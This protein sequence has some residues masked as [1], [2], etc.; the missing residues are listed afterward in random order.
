[1][2]DAETVVYR[3]GYPYISFE[4]EAHIHMRVL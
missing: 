2:E 3:K 4:D 1:M